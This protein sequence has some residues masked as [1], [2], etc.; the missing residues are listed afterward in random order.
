MYV[1]PAV[2]GDTVYAGS[3]SGTYYAL[4]TQTG[5]VRWSFDTSVD[6]QPATFHTNPLIHGELVVTATDG[7]ADGYIYAFDRKTGAVRWKKLLMHGQVV[8]DLVQAGAAVFA[9]AYEGHLVALAVED[10][11]ELWTFPPVAAPDELGGYAI[12]AGEVVY[13]AGRDRHVHAL[14]AEDGQ[15]LWQ[16]SLG[17]S[18]NTTLA[19]RGEQL[20]VGCTDDRLYRLDAKSGEITARFETEESPGGKLVAL[21]GAIVYLGQEP[22]TLIAAVDPDLSKLLWKAESRSWTT[23]RPLLW[24]DHLVAGD[25]GGT[26]VGLDPAD[27]TIAWSGELGGQLRGLGARDDTLFVG[28]IEGKLYAYWM[29]AESESGAASVNP[30]PTRSSTRRPR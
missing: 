4:N 1:Q 25:R 19:M 28:T 10:G 8:A 18:V 5:E 22:S 14:R 9:L 27:G 21:P 29:V 16:R 12:T 2:A 23:V 30:P 11:R 6:G 24:Q 13:L 26:L 7:A 17:A 3:C 15:V 20:Y